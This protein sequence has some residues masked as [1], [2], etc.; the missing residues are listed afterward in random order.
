MEWGDEWGS[1]WGG[2]L[3]PITTHVE[4]AQ[5][6]LPDWNDKANNRF[7]AGGLGEHTQKLEDVIINLPRLY[8]IRVAYAYYQDQLGSILN[9]PRNAQADAE[10][11]I[12]LQ[13]RGHLIKKR[14]TSEDLL[15]LVRLLLNDPSRDFTLTD[16]Y[17]KAYKLE[18]D[19]LTEAE[20]I[21]FSP[22]LR[23][24]KPATY[25][26]K[27]IV[28]PPLAFGHGDASATLPAPPPPYGFGDASGTIPGLG[29]PLAYIVPI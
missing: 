8:D 16:T 25:I 3:A 7:V 20:I 29:G 19:N 18:I 15:Q 28:V 6:R 13:A 11:R 24:S 1:L 4:D 23:L 9:Q 22:F 17:P 12:F 10:Y 27:F 14:R 5:D 21:A 2:N 26:G